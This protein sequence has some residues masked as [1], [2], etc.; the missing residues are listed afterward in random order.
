MSQVHSTKD[1]SP[2]WSVAQLS[3]ALW[4]QVDC[5]YMTRLRKFGSFEFA[6]KLAFN[7]SK[8]YNLMHMFAHVRRFERTRLTCLSL[9]L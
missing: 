9:Q 5:T 8:V 1:F 2:T 7:F 6:P 4:W 3:K